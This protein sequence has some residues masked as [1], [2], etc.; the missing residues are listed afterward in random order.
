MGDPK[1]IRKKYETPIHPWQKSRI[2]EE[3]KLLKEYKLKNKKELWKFSSI[4]KKYKDQAKKLIAM[5]GTQADLE[6][7]QMMNKLKSF[8]LITVGSETFDA[9]FSLQIKDVLDR[10]LQT[11]LFKKGLARSQKQAR[12]FIIHGH[13]LI[14]DK[15]I[16]SPRYL[17]PIKEEGFINFTVSSSLYS[18]DHPERKAIDKK[19]KVILKK[20]AEEIQKDIKSKP[21][22]GNNTNIKSKKEETP[23]VEEKK[24]STPK[25][26]V[27][28]GLVVKEKTKP[29]VKEEKKEPIK[30]IKV[31]KPSVKEKKEE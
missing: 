2:V 25:K 27:K 10:M 29:I 19:T 18:E 20:E 17:V 4:L 1:K 23:S 21:K 31:E 26:E 6:R 15:K 30:D 12:Q 13:V 11:V 9:I 16:T 28:K 22:E 24:E 8:G 3:I 7:E 14:G 5:Q